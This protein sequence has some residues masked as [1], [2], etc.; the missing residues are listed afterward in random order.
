MLRTTMIA[1]A[2]ATLLGI[3]EASAAPMHGSGIA[4]AAQAIRLASRSTTIL[5][6]RCNSLAVVIPASPP[7]MIQTSQASTPR[8]GAATSRAGAVASYQVCEDFTL[9]SPPNLCFCPSF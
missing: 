7:P 2:A 4:A 3:A 8:S 5:P 9:I 6:R 1:L